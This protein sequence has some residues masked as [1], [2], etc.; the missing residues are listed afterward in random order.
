MTE[1]LITK[2]QRTRKGLNYTEKVLIKG[3]DRS[4]ISVRQK[5]K[6]RSYLF[7]QKTSV[8]LKKIRQLRDK[9]L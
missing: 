7:Y 9:D 8:I 6:N 2:K 1:N 3:S 4:S 5:Q